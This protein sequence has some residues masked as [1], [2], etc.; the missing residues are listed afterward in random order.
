MNSP[1]RPLW[2]AALATLAAG[3]G[4]AQSHSAALSTLH[5]PTEVDSPTGQLRCRA[6][7]TAAEGNTEGSTGL[8]FVYP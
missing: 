3:A 2:L 8:E 7:I 1:L 4:L 5:V 6:V